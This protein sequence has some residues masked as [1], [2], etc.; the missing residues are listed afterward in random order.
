[1][2]QDYRAG[3]HRLPGYDDRRSDDRSPDDRGYR[4]RRYGG[5]DQEAASRFNRAEGIRRVRR[6][7]NWTAAA[8]IAGVAVTTGYFAH[9]ATVASQQA[10]SP[11]TVSTGQPGTAVPGHKATANNPVATSGGS[12]A[13]GQAGTG[14]SGHQ[15]NANH[16]V[17]TSGGSGATKGRDN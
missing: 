1:M 8:L 6:T 17:V 4:G 2:D 13:T 3:R 10:T 14:A 16:T 15:A 7:S 11:G 9:A 5:P 12:G